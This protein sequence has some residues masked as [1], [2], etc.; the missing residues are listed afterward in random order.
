MLNDSSNCLLKF[1]GIPQESRTVVKMP[2]AKSKLH[3][4]VFLKSSAIIT[5]T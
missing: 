2:L 1:F 4:P 3:L 5:L